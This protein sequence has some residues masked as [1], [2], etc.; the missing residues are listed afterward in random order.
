MPAGNPENSADIYAAPVI[1]IGA[2][3]AGLAA[4]LELSKHDTRCL[5]LESGSAVGGLA[6]TVDYK[7]YL[8]DIGGHR[9]ITNS[10][11]V[12]QIWQETL[13]PDLLIRRRL[14]RIYYRS[15]FYHYPLEPA[16]VLAGLGLR[17]SL[18]CTASYAKARLL[19]IRPELD[20]ESWISNRFGRRLFRTFFKSYTEKVWGMSCGE[21]SAEWAAQRIQGLSLRSLLW[22]AATGRYGNG[23]SAI[24]TLASQFYYPRRGP[25]M[26]WSR[27]QERIEAAGSRVILSAP[28]DRIHWADGRVTAVSA[29]GRLYHGRHFI[30]TM[31][32]RDLIHALDPV[33][34]LLRRVADHFRYRDFLTVALVLRGAHLFPDNW[35]YV[36]EPAVRVGRIQNYKNWSPEMV[37]DADT[38]LLGLEYFCNE[39]DSLWSMSDDELVHLGRDELG[40]LGLIEPSAMKDGT[41]VRI[42]KAYPV[43]D[44]NYRQGLSVVREFLATVPNLQVI[45]RNGMHRYN[46]Q[47]HSMLTGILAARNTMGAN[48]DIWHVNEKTAYREDGSVSGEL[49]KVWSM[50]PAVPQRITAG[51]R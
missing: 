42:K 38:T 10:M 47:D 51:A 32:L 7:G 30:S 43:Y 8:F 6:R 19:P 4:G 45:G 1:V 20:F 49:D 15:K 46:N 33:P 39:G 11:L 24:R 28:V 5:V 40:L 37:P 26:M 3:P 14:S 27:V 29:G 12:Q 23:S 25:G 21:I 44:D 31:A 22:N 2:G 16:N 35:I 36:H 50:Q 9:F 34:P 48:Y 13:G 41:V 17:E 18:A